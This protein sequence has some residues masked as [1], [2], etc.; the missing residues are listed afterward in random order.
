MA[1][2]ETPRKDFR[3][4]AEEIASLAPG[5]GACIATDR[6]VVDGCKVGYMYREEPDNR[7]DSGWRF[8]AGDEDEAYTAD[9]DRLGVY[10][11]NTVV[12]H[13]PAVL[14]FLDAPEGSRFERTDDDSFELLDDGE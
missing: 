11:V 2:E 14:P 9:P 4:S 5:L 12:N 6:V 10:E 13:D 7:T 3:L 1:G 8:F